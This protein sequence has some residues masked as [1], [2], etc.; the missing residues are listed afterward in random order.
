M[1][2]RPQISSDLNHRLHLWEG[3]H[4]FAN[5][6]LKKEEKAKRLSKK[7]KEEDI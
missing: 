4:L 2:T 7:N 3:N 5:P 1:T 6:V